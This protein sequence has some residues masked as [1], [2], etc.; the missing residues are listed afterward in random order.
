MFGLVYV[1]IAIAMLFIIGPIVTMRPSAKERRQA[2]IRQAASER[3]VSTTPISLK[4]NKKLNH[5]LQRNPHIEKYH[6]FRYQLVAK[7]DEP[8]PSITGEWTQRKDRDG[9]LVW[10][11]ADIKQ[12]E[13]PL[14]AE[15]IQLWQA[16]QNEDFLK[17]ELTPRGA[18]IVWNERGDV[19]ETEALC[20]LLKKLMQS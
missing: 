17:L 14:V 7:E 19:A 3:G 18:A 6:W 8:S 16:Q 1:L 15:L 5:L 2:R 9:T 4:T 11:A 12:Q 13:P 20:D 10:E